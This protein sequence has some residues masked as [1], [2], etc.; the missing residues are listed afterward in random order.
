MAGSL[1]HDMIYEKNGETG[2][3]TGL[4]NGGWTS[5][6]TV[7]AH[8]ICIFTGCWPA[9]SGV[10]LNARLWM[11]LGTST[12][13]P[14]ANR[15]TEAIIKAAIA[16]ISAMSKESGKRRQLSIFAQQNR[17]QWCRCSWNP[18]VEHMTNCHRSGMW[19]CWSHWKQYRMV[20]KGLLQEGSNMAWC[21]SQ[22]SRRFRIH[23]NHWMPHQQFHWEK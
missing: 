13:S 20:A 5:K 19:W 10:F 18:P 21:R 7:H 11:L 14:S 8:G 3:P 22:A 9:S 23:M 15:A 17:G 1:N 12:D 16:I 4:R 6:D 2:K